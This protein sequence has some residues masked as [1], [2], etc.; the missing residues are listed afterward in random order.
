[1]KFSPK[2][3]YQIGS[4]PFRRISFH[5]LPFSQRK[6]AVLQVR[7]FRLMTIIIKVLVCLYWYQSN[8]IEVL[9]LSIGISVLVSK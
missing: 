3:L 9:V 1:M 8:A 7:R 6:N 4:M 2:F 5:Q